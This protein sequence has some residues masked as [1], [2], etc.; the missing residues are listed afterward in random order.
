MIFSITVCLISSW[1]DGRVVLGRDD[2]R[3]HPHRLVP[4]VLDRHLALAVRPQPGDLA[5]V[6]GGGE[7]PRQT[8]CEGDGQRHHLRRL[9][10]GEAEHQPLVAGATGIHSLGD[11]GRLRVDG[12]QHG[13]GLAVEAEAGLRVADLLD[14]PAGHGREVDVGV[15]GDLAGQENHTGGHQGLTGHP[16][17]RVLPQHFVQNSIGDL[18]G[19]LVGMALRHGFRGEQVDISFGHKFVPQV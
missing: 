16:A 1:E 11:V 6:P 14:H 18:V 8:V 7:A 12:R 3:V 9:T 4:L 13:A 5:R 10:T 2:D 15:G 19:H 17:R